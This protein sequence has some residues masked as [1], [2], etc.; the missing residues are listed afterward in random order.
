MP[1]AFGWLPVKGHP[2]VLM[3][4]LTVVLVFCVSLARAAC[5][6]RG[7]GAVAVPGTGMSCYD[8]GPHPCIS[9]SGECYSC[10]G[11]N[12]Q[13]YS[14]TCSDGITCTNSLST[15]PDCGGGGQCF[16]QAREWPNC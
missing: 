2:F 3:Q 12:G 13:C 5:G 8:C 1:S 10:A 7:S 4:S 15:C 9:V 16:K 14:Y 6:T 11:S